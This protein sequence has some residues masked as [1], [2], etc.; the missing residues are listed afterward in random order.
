MNPVFIGISRIAV[1][2]AILILSACS[3]GGG[4]PAPATIGGFVSGLAGSALVLADN[5]SDHL[6]VSGNGAFA[7]AS[8]IPVG[9]A[10]SV[11][12]V[13]E[14]KSPSQSCVVANGSGRAGVTAV[15]NVSVTCTTNSY[16]VGG[17]VYGLAGSAI[18]LSDNRVDTISVNNDGD[19]AFPTPIASGSAYTVTITA[20]PTDLT[21]HCTVSDG[22][23]TVGGTAVTNLAVRCAKAG[24]FIYITEHLMNAQGGNGGLPAGGVLAYAIDPTTGAFQAIPGSPFATDKCPCTLSVTPDG[25]F[26]FVGSGG[27]LYPYRIDELTGALSVTGAGTGIGADSGSIGAD[28]KSKFVYVANPATNTLSAYAIAPT[29]GTLTPVT[30]SPFPSGANPS[31]PDFDPSGKF[32]YVA[33]RGSNVISAYAIDATSGALKAIPGSPF[34][35][36]GIPDAVSV[37]GTGHFLY[38][39]N[40]S[41]SPLAS[42]AIDAATGA[43]SPT[44]TGPL[45]PNPPPVPGDASAF[46]LDPNSNHG[47]LIGQC[48]NGG[49]NCA[50]VGGG[51]PFDFHLWPFAIDNQ[52]G[53]FI[54]SGAS[55][56]LF[57]ID[58]LSGLS[59]MQ[60]DPSGKFVCARILSFDVAQQ[61]LFECYLIDATTGAPGAALGNIGSFPDS[62]NVPVEDWDAITIAR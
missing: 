5:G 8:K 31:A 57:A 39:T 15:T 18:Q 41:S 4:S 29:S 13:T 28:P 26:A 50:T 62:G 21:Q 10:Y 37:E 54:Q 27:T 33:N 60:I 40:G 6:A 32:L 11:S 1:A 22:I 20:Q 24:R 35:A 34:A 52:S 38:A 25:K 56:H 46:L 12:V 7:F 49:D 36:S 47:Y 23:G 59:S 14:P 2:L 44:A 42:F 3:G 48:N 55:Q 43:L 17:A 16:T 9:S 19:F 61:T 51:A 58:E 53:A 45:T 30:G